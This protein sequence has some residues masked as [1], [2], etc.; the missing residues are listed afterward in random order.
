MPANLSGIKKN[1]QAKQAMKTGPKGTF[2]ISWTQTEVDGLVAA[3]IDML[4]VGAL[5]RWTGAVV[6]V[7]GQ[8]DL[9]RLE[10]PEG[11]ADMRRR[12]ARVVRRLVGAAVSGDVR[13]LQGDADIPDD[14]LDRGFIVTDGRQS[15]TV[16]LIPVPDTGTRLLMFVGDLP[17]ADQDLWVVRVSADRTH[18]AAGAIQEGGVICFTPDTRIATPDG[19]RAIQMLRPGDLILTKDN[20]PQEILWTGH[21]RMTGA[22]LYAMPHLRPVRFRAG[23]FGIG[24]PDGDLIVSPQHRMLVKGRAAQNLF[25]TPEVLVRAED[26]I[27]GHSVMVDHGLREVTYIHILLERHNIVFANGIE[28]E[29]FHPSNTALDTVEPMQRAALVQ[30]LPGVAVNPHAYGDYARRNLSASEAAILRHDRA[31]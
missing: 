2:V 25:N 18:Q 8:G 14:D 11:A 31:A 19:P 10:G 15:F 23:A 6:R 21:R 30:V 3:P 1:E 9:L 22:R 7:D 16:T 4:A 20:G 13:P 12:A 5:W 29:S 17:P 24:Q 26:L 28:T 27:N